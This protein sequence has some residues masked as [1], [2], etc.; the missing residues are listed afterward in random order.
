MMSDIS[1][2]LPF[3]VKITLGAAVTGFP[4]LLASRKYAATVGGGK[5]K[6]R[7]A[8][9]MQQN[10]IENR[11]MPKHPTHMPARSVTFRRG[12]ERFQIT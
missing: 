4:S 7:A 8:A 5:T 10:T 12:R 1:A 2:Q 9:A 11:Q 3:S 6:L